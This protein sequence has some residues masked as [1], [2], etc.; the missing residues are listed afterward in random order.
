MEFFFLFVFFVGKFGSGKTQIFQTNKKTK[1]RISGEK[2]TQTFVNGWV[3]AHRTRVPIFR[4][5]PRSPKTGVNIG[6]R[7]HLGRY[8]EL[9]CDQ[10]L[11]SGSSHV[12]RA[13]HVY[14]HASFSHTFLGTMVG[15]LKLYT[16]N[17]IYLVC[18]IS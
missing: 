11:T 16:H 17:I 4:V 14:I 3:G 2:N 8:V 9:A 1:M 5:Y 18:T 7:T 12:R 15:L 13:R 6:C 10:V